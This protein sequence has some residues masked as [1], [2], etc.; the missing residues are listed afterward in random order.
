[1]MKKLCA[2]LLTAVMVIGFAACNS[3]EPTK[4][5]EIGRAHV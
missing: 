4:G 3:A 2:L 5:D 1:M